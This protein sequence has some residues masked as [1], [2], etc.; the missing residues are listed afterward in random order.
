M[1]PIDHTCP[2]CHAKPGAWC[3]Q[4]K[5]RRDAGFHKARELAAKGLSVSVQDSTGMF[6]RKK[7][8]AK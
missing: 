2:Q 8:G 1:N 7:R 6:N 4:G 5:R 3:T